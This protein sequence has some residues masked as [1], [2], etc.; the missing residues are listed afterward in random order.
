MYDAEAC[1]SGPH[2]AGVFEHELCVLSIGGFTGNTQTRISP[3]SQRIYRRPTNIRLT[4][5]AKPA[6]RKVLICSRATTSADTVGS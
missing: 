6:I 5:F 2:F 1:S 4:L 3:T